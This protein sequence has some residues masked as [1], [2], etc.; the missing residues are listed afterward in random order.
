MVTRWVVL[1]AAYVA[2]VVY[3][4]LVPLE[5]HPLP[6]SE[7]WARFQQIPFL[8]LGVES[9]ADW[10]ANGVLYV[11]VGFLG[12]LVLLQRGWSRLAAAIVAIVAALGLAVAVEYAQLFFPPRTVSLNDLL[13][14][15]IGSVAGAVAAAVVWPMRARWQPLQQAGAGWL[16][17]HGLALYAGAYLAYSLFPYDFL[18][19]GAELS[20]KLASGNWGWWL[21]D[22][23]GRWLVTV[24]RLGV[25]VLLAAPLGTWLAARRPSGSMRPSASF[26]AGLAIGLAIELTQLLLAS[27]VTQGASVLARAVGV[28]VGAGLWVHRAAWSPARVRA[29]VL[30]AAPWVLPVYLLVLLGV[31]GWF[32]CS[33]ASCA[34]SSVGTWATSPCSRGSSARSSSCSRRWPAMAFGTSTRPSSPPASWRPR[35]SS[36]SQRGWAASSV[37]SW[38]LRRRRSG[39]GTW[40]SNCAAAVPLRAE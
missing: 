12:A 6:P 19:S 26:G 14:E 27:G 5:F 3:G 39:S 7:A 9:R 20:E 18:I 28:A 21:A 10:I 31:N 35:G 1:L 8:R 38:W 32:S 15:A 16:H 25:E 33:W 30:R 34:V 36:R 37:E 2:F 17:H 23:D 4:S 13:A 22:G 24:A 40:P 29:T 11:P